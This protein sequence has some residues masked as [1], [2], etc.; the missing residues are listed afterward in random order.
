MGQGSDPVQ[1]ITS[2]AVAMVGVGARRG[3]RNQGPAPRQCPAWSSCPQTQNYRAAQSW[4]EAQS[5]NL[6]VMARLGGD[7]VTTGQP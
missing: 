1:V 6:M 3:G 5:H 7:S 4:A 2:L